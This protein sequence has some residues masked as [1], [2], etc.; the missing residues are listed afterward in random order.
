MTIVYNIMLAVDDTVGPLV[1]ISKN[2]QC[3]S[4][5]QLQISNQQQNNK[6]SKMNHRKRS[7]RGHQ[8]NH[9]HLFK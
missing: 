9:L 5:T 2:S 3:S 6:D 4:Y 7:D 1:G 8:S